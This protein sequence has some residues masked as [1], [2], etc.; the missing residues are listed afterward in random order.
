MI[1]ISPWAATQGLMTGAG[2]LLPVGGSLVLYGAYIEPG[3]ETAPTNLLF[4]LDLKA[5]NPAW[6]LRRLPYSTCLTPGK[7]LIDSHSPGVAW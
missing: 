4:D 7:F 2:H 5:R 6:G 3:I 1:H